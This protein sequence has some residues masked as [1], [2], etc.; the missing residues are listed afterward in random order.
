MSK[1][2]VEK[3]KKF[4]LF[5]SP[6]ELGNYKILDPEKACELFSVGYNATKEKLKDAKI[7]K[8]FDL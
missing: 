1:E 7:K 4:D 5:V 6:V 3:S 8:I 2:I